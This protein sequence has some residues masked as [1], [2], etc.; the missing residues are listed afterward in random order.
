MWSSNVKRHA[1][2]FQT[3]LMPTIDWRWLMGIGVS[4]I[5]RIAELE[6]NSPANWRNNPQT[7]WKL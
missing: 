7:T 3:T 2:C 6:C 1:N 5:L 4:T